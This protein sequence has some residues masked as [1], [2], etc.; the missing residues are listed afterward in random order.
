MVRLSV[1][2][3]MSLPLTWVLAVVGEVMKLAIWLREVGRIGHYRRSCH[4][5]SLI[6][7]CSGCSAG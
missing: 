4:Y 3:T 2:I 5:E 6:W 1:P 7:R